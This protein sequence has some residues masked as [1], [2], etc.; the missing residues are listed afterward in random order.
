M[1][2]A[3]ANGIE[4]EYETFGDRSS[5]PLILIM[6]LASQM[7]MWDEAFC[8]RLAER[9]RFVIRFDNRDIGL[10]TRLTALEVPNVFAAM[11]ATARGE[12]VKAPYSIE[13]MGDDTVG[14]LDALS[15]EKAHVCGASMGGMIAQA[16]AIRHPSR[17]LSLISIMSTTGEPGLPPPRPEA[18]QALLTPP[19]GNRAGFIEQGLKTWRAIGS[20]GFPFHEETMRA[21]MAQT[22]DRGYYPAGVVRQLMAIITQAGRRSAL[23]AVRVP[24]LVIHGAADPLVPVE[25]GRDTASSV[26]GAK[27]MLI[28][29]MGHDLPPELWPR[30]V[31]AI[32]SLT[33]K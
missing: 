1:P 24:T 5:P 18:M 19:P 12:T 3:Q 13:D 9:G 23:S 25:C 16:V 6:G 32:V 11:A 4:L 22:Y 17:V 30:L 27:L 28:E 15:I 26:P 8:R 29:G 10:S 20:P 31:D 14:L 21:K 2:K 7:I 33:G